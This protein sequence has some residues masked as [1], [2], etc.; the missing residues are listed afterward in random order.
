MQN[1]P[2]PY[3]I[4]LGGQE[5]TK[6]PR[7]DDA[8]LGG[9]SQSRSLPTVKMNGDKAEIRI[10]LRGVDKALDRVRLLGFDSNIVLEALQRKAQDFKIKDALEESES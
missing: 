7:P 2:Q 10:A 9:H 1:Q 8:V 4:V 3:D 5:A 6:S